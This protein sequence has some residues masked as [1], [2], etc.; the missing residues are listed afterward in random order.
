MQPSSHLS[1]LKSIL[2][3][4]ENCTRIGW[5]YPLKL[6]PRTT[7]KFVLTPYP[8]THVVSIYLLRLLPSHLFTL[9][10]FPKPSTSHS[11]N[12][13]AK[14]KK[15]KK[16][17]DRGTQNRSLRRL[18]SGLLAFKAD[19]FYWP[20]IERERGRKVIPSRCCFKINGD[21]CVRAVFSFFCW[22]N[23]QPKKGLSFSSGSMATAKCARIKYSK[24]SRDKSKQIDIS[25]A[26]KTRD[27]GGGVFTECIPRHYLSSGMF[28]VTKRG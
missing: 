9:V 28:W 6:W 24:D 15:K 17:K 26:K 16:G 7:S 14:E 21:A 27:G 12:T 18:F 20:S 1:H 22:L 8:R 3:N 5:K 25:W 2:F 10:H 19:L 11:G 4:I 13:I 23:S